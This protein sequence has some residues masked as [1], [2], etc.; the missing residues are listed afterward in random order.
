[1]GTQDARNT[2]QTR[3]GVKDS[4]DPRN[5]WGEEALTSPEQKSEPPTPQ[6]VLG[7]KLALTPA[8]SPRRGGAAA[9]HGN[10][11]TAGVGVRHG[12]SR[13]LLRFLESSLTH[14]KPA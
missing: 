14:T 8:L 11:M 3:D 1:M 2:T 9:G 6:L 13:R 5:R 10:F 4:R 7:K 12:D